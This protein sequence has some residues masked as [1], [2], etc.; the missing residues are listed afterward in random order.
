MLI[1]CTLGLEIVSGRFQFDH[2][3][4]KSLRVCVCNIAS[5]VSAGVSECQPL[6]MVSFVHQNVGWV[7]EALDMPCVYKIV[8]R[9]V[10]YCL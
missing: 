3:E 2:P 7:A 1:D 5:R 9:L 4:C 8:Q 6:C 10:C